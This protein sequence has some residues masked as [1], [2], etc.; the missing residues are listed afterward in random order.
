MGAVADV[1]KINNVRYSV[2]LKS[3]WFGLYALLVDDFDVEYAI[4]KYYI[5]NEQVIY[6]KWQSNIY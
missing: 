5:L 3:Y 6:I 1:V 4:P 2:Q